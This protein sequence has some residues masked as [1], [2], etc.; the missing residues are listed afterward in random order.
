MYIIADCY[1]LLLTRFRIDQML[2]AFQ[3]LAS[4]LMRKLSEMV[5]M[6]GGHKE[7]IE[8]LLCKFT[9]LVHQQRHI[10]QTF[11]EDAIKVV[12]VHKHGSR[13]SRSF[14]A[15]GVVRIQACHL[16]ILRQD[17]VELPDQTVN[18]MAETFNSKYNMQLKLLTEAVQPDIV[19]HEG[20]RII[21]AV[22]AGPS[23]GLHDPVS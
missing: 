2:A 20:D 16:N 13:S 12:G 8:Q 9:N 23:N 22:T 17:L 4:P 5:K 15:D 18:K 1:S 21:D 3:T 14:V 6:E 11:P 10:H 7:V 19:H